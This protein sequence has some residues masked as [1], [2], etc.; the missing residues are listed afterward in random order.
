VITRILG[1]ELE[2]QLKDFPIVILLGP[3]Q[4]G[5]TTLTKMVLPDFNYVTLEDPETRTIA[6][7]DPK[8]LLKRYP[9]K[10]IFDEI[11]R[12]PHLL[13][14]LQTIVDASQTNGQFVLTG[15]HQL[16][17]HQAISQSL[18][19]RTGML[20]LLPLSI[21]ELAGNGMTFDSFETYLFHGFLPRVY[22]QKQRPQSAYSSVSV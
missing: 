17:L 6:H 1:K 22:S 5:K 14:Y 13:S 3:R 4:A 7:E 2:R 16:E 8:A 19:G 11:Q 18:A 15:S 10:T 20:H 12:C 9:T 21:A